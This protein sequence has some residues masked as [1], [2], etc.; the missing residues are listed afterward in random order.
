MLFCFVR[1]LQHRRHPSQSRAKATMPVRVMVVLGSGGHTAEMLTAIQHLDRRRFA[2][3]SYI[4]ADSDQGSLERAQAFEWKLATK[5]AIPPTFCTIP[6]SR[7]VG[8]SYITSIWT[9]L[10]AFCYSISVI[11]KHRPQ[12]VCCLLTHALISLQLLCNGPGTCIP[13]VW[14][15]FISEVLLFRRCSIVFLESFCRVRSI[16]ASGYLVWPIADRF[17]VQWPESQKLLPLLEY[18]RTV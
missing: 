13:L 17:I 18:K 15:A 3:V 11:V 12:L 8:Q 1:K 10:V 14:L 9:T 5:P 16:S 4:A 6:R 2:P 7:Y